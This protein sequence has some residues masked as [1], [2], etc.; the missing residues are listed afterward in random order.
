MFLDKYKALHPLR[1]RAMVSM[2]EWVSG[3]TFL[4][5]FGLG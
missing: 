2:L 4:L 3:P 5:G 1:K